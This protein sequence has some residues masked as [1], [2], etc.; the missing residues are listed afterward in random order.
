MEIP[1]SMHGF[2]FI[3][4][5]G[6]SDTEKKAFT[7][8]EA[9]TIKKHE[10]QIEGSG[11]IYRLHTATEEYWITCFGYTYDTKTKQM[12]FAPGNFCVVILDKNYKLKRIQPGA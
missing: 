4:E 12:I 1:K 3:S 6:L 8:A 10:K 11:Q 2:H 5:L 7:A 9:A